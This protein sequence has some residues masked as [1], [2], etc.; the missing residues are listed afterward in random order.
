L[1]N[2]DKSHSSHAHH[3]DH[4]HK[5]H[6]IHSH[7]AQNATTSDYESGHSSVSYLKKQLHAVTRERDEAKAA[8]QKAQTEIKEMNRA[9]ADAARLRTSHDHMRQDL[10]A[11]KMSLESSERI[12]KQQKSLI[13]FI[14]KSNSMLDGNI[15]AIDLQSVD[16]R[17][18]DSRSMSIDPRSAGGVGLLGGVSHSLQGNSLPP[19]PVSVSGRNPAANRSGGTSLTPSVVVANENRSW[20]MNSYPGIPPSSDMVS[21]L[22][23]DMD[24]G[25]GSMNRSK[26]RDSRNKGNGSNNGTNNKSARARG[27][28][29]VGVEV[30]TSLMNA[31]S[32]P[33]QP[34][35]PVYRPRV[36]YSTSKKTPLPKTTATTVSRRRGKNI[37]AASGRPPLPPRPPST[38]IGYKGVSAKMTTASRARAAATNSSFSSANTAKSAYS[39]KKKIPSSSFGV[40]HF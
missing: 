5:H 9:F 11:L 16:S 1:T 23:I 25:E 35:T 8:L 36:E 18:L 27:S 30:L 13:A 31:V 33:G 7:T 19:P 34:R 37:A 6:H 4:V 2:A 21:L 14:Q 20:L 12:R 24:M 22:S 32:R 38:T 39:N 29:A 3:S 17:S 15:S 26:G 28:G 10:E 40:G